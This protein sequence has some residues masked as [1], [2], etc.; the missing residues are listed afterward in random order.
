L[1]ITKGQSVKGEVI[2]EMFKQEIEDDQDNK[3]RTKLY[4]QEVLIALKRVRL[5]LGEVSSTRIAIGGWL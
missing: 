1:A 3:P 2:I 4:K 5:N